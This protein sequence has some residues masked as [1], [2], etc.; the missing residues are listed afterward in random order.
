MAQAQSLIQQLQDENQRLKMTAAAVQAD[1]SAKNDA[2]QIAAYRAETERMRAQHQIERPSRLP[3][4]SD[5]DPF[6]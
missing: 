2:N 1:R 4:A 6:G 3:G 5:F